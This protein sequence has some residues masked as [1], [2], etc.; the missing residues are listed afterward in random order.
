MH[1]SDG[2]LLATS[3]R[4]RR[5]NNSK[6]SVSKS[7]LITDNMDMKVVSNYLETKHKKNASMAGGSKDQSFEVG[8]RSVCKEV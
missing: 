7:K 1:E 4:V 5:R 6:V 2:E 3:G 8:K